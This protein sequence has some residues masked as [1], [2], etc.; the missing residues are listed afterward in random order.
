MTARDQET[1]LCSYGFTWKNLELQYLGILINRVLNSMVLDNIQPFIS[2]MDQ[3]F[4]LWSTLQVSFWGT[5]QMIKMVTPRFY[6][7]F[8]KLPLTIPAHML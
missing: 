7:V 2:R 5:I 3:D 6:Y 8:G 1:T 4:T